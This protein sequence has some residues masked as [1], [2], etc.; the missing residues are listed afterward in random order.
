MA[1]AVAGDARLARRAG[2]QQH[3]TGRLPVDLPLRPALVPRER[4]DAT[5]ELV[6]AMYDAHNLGRI[7]AEDGGGKIR[8]GTT[9]LCDVFVSLLRQP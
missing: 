7:D 6:A 4:G 9:E 2:Q 5:A 1:A 3:E 8:R